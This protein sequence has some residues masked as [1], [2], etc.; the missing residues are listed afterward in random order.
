MPREQFVWQDGCWWPVDALAAEH[1]AEFLSEAEAEAELE[2]EFPSEPEVDDDV[3]IEFGTVEELAALDRAGRVLDRERREREAFRRA[4]LRRS[5]RSRTRRGRPR[6]R[7][8]RARSRSTT[9]TSLS[10]SDPPSQPDVDP[11]PPDHVGRVRV[12]AA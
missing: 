5:T 12:E 6:P 9:G 1:E 7:G 10:G 8:R 2:I 11:R 3:E 4:L